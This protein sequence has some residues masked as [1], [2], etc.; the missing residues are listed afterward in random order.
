[1]NILYWALDF[2]LLAQVRLFI[3]SLEF[4]LTLW[5]NHNQFF[6]DFEMI[7]K[8]FPFDTFVAM[9]A[10]YISFWTVVSLN[11]KIK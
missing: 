8:L 4:F 10:I 7:I 6:T 3:L 2:F 11:I 1:M 9:R 5:A